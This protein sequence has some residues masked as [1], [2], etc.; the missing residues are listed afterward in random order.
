[1]YFTGTAT[2][3]VP[4]WESRLALVSHVETGW[5]DGDGYA[6][7]PHSSELAR[8]ILAEMDESGLEI[9]GIFPGICHDLSDGEVVRLEWRTDE[10]S[11]TWDCHR[12][13]TVDAFAIRHFFDELGNREHE[14]VDRMFHWDGSQRPFDGLI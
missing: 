9:P 4:A 7:H 10:L 14:S 6:I 13:G 12:D 2:L 3:D 11:A 5:F 8:A 1:M